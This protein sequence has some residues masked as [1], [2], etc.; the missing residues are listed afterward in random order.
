MDAVA[1][2]SG[3]EGGG[4]EMDA[5]A[6]GAGTYTLQVYLERSHSWNEGGSLLVNLDQSGANATVTPWEAMF[7]VTNPVP[8]SATMSLLGLAAL[9][10]VIRLKRKK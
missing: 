1:F 3:N 2:Q 8:E 5:L 9:A 4:I 6:G 7:T 10:M